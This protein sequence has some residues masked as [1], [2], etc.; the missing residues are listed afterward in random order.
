MQTIDSHTH[1]YPKEVRENP[2][3][4]AESRNER[5]WAELVAPKVKPSLQGWASRTEMLA[6]MDEAGVGHAV[7][8]G[9]Y[10]EHEATCRWHNHS[11]AEWVRTA[12]DRLSG[13]AAI[14]PGQSEACIL[15]QLEEARA[16]GLV[17]VGELHPGIQR[18]GSQTPGWRM[19]ADW[20]AQN[21]WPV[22]IHATETAGHDHPASIPT[23]LNDFLRMAS[24]SPDL[25]IILAHWGGGLPFFEL[26]PKVKDSLQNVYY[27]SAASPLLYHPSIFRRVIDIVGSNKILFGSDYPLRLYPRGAK[28]PGF[29]RFLQSIREEA[30]LTKEELDAVFH[31]NAQNLLRHAG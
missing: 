24:E 23:P 27:D 9:W 7:L 16:L 29:S 5:H 25:K 13:F 10:W 2:R 21:A 15:E 14:H 12:P 31:H 6:A 18:F 28:K 19:I 4:W 17:G 20:C 22:L 8:T 11:I 30:H 26:N 1:C 3:V